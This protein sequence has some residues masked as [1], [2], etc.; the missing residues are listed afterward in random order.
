[1]LSLGI[2]LVVVTDRLVSVFGWF[3]GS[4]VKLETRRRLSEISLSLVFSFFSPFLGILI[5][6]RSRGLKAGRGVAVVLRW[7]CE[8]RRSPENSRVFRRLSFFFLF[9]FQV[10]TLSTLKKNFRPRMS[11]T[12]VPTRGIFLL[13]CPHAPTGF[14]TL[15]IPPQ[16]LNERNAPVA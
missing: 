8:T 4:L 2:L 12:L 1:M 7:V 10:V 5:G 14:L 13:F 6:A 9:L 11:Q 16:Y 15:V 3:G